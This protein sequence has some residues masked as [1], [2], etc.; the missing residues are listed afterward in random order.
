M[1]GRLPS[2]RSRT[3]IASSPAKPPPRT[4]MRVMAGGFLRLKQRELGTRLGPDADLVVAGEARVTELDRVAARRL[5]HALQRVVA[6][7]IRADVATDFLDGVAGP[8]EL[9]SR[10]RVDAVV[11]GPLDRRRRDPHVDLAGAG[12]T[13][14]PHDLPARRPTHDRVVHDDHPTAFEHLAH[15]IELH[16]DAEVTDALL[17]LDERTADIVVADQAHLVPGARLLRVAERRARSRVGDR[18]HDVGL[19]RMLAGE[20]AAERL[21]H[22]VD[23]AAPQHG[24][25][26][27]EVHIFEHAVLA[28]DRREGANR[29]R[30]GVGDGDDLAGL[31]LALEL[32]LD[33]VERARLG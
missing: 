16:L 20:L 31:H 8:D 15:R 30:A 17:G 23:V 5:Q 28:L 22:G 25:G 19:D 4:T 18:D 6:E 32:R 2:R 13:D 12:T 14:H 11:T 9:L 24:V 3:R 33:E 29:F 27:R 1:S 7:R 26:A 21:A 10:R